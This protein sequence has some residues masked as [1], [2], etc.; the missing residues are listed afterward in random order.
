MKIAIPT[1][2][3]RRISS[4]IQSINGFNI[5]EISNGEIIAETY[6]SKKSIQRLEE[7]ADQENSNEKELS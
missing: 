6:I 1:R 2:D 7:E 5:Y 3:G 4:N